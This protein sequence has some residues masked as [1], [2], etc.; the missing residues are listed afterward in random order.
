MLCSTHSDHFASLTDCFF[1][2]NMQHHHVCHFPSKHFY[3]GSLVSATVTRTEYFQFCSHFQSMEKF[4]PSSKDKPTVFYSVQGRE[5][6][7]SSAEKVRLQS[8]CNHEEARK[9]VSLRKIFSGVATLATQCMVSLH[10]HARTY[11]HRYSYSVY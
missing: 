8:K 9:I 1:Q 11:V 5:L 2:S 3:D 10:K 4:W 7:P 6:S